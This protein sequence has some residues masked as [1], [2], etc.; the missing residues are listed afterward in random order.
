MLLPKNR[1]KRTDAVSSCLFIS[2]PAF[3][4]SFNAPPT[5]EIA[6]V[7]APESRLPPAMLPMLPSNPPPELPPP[8]FRFGDFK[9]PSLA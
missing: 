8:K 3:Q 6:E 7:I 5:P 2:I 4:A 1:E 9:L